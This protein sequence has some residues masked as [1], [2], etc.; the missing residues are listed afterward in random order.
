MADKWLE[1]NTPRG[2]RDIQW[3]PD[4]LADKEIIEIHH[5][6]LAWRWPTA[7]SPIQRYFTVLIMDMPTAEIPA[8]VVKPHSYIKDHGH[9][10]LTMANPHLNW[11]W[12][13][14]TGFMLAYERFHTPFPIPRRVFGVAMAYRGA[15]MNVLWLAIRINYQR[16]TLAE[17]DYERMLVEHSWKI[18]SRS[19]GSI[20]P[21]PSTPA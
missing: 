17:D 4:N 9:N 2:H 7:T 13:T 10:M 16:R 18:S 15:D 21:G 11:H 8:Y 6:E 3:F 1:L 14:G 20:I 12:G 5:I 19:P